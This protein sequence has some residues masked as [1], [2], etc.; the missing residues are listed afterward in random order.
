MTTE[1]GRIDDTP[2]VSP[3]T[4]KILGLPALRDG[5]KSLGPASPE[6]ISLLKLSAVIR[7]NAQMILQ[8]LEPALQYMRDDAAEALAQLHRQLYSPTSRLMLANAANKDREAESIAWQSIQSQHGF[9]VVRSGRPA[10]RVDDSM[11]VMIMESDIPVGVAAEPWQEAGQDAP[12]DDL[13]TR[14]VEA[15][16]TTQVA[17][18]EQ[19]APAAVFPDSTPAK[20]S[21]PIAIV[22]NSEQHSLTKLPNEE[23]IAKD[24]RAALGVLLATQQPGAVVKEKKAA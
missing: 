19:H 18:S 16:S 1:T 21:A 8:P 10:F 6:C 2:K 13:A 11:I 23:D 9:D 14:A 4:L 15:A 5:E 22:P 3:E 24:P 12:A 7:A 20:E 17:A